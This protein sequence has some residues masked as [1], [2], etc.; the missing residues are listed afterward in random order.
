[1]SDQEVNN[2]RSRNQKHNTQVVKQEKKNSTNHDGR[3]QSFICK[4]R[5]LITLTIAFFLLEPFTKAESFQILIKSLFLAF[6]IV[7]FQNNTE[8]EHADGHFAMNVVF[9]VRQ[10]RDSSRQ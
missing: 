10:L 9:A 6:A 7:M 3:I 2:M 4:P 1:M 5:F 8:S